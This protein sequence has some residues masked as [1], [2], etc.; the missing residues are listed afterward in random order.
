MANAVNQAEAL[1]VALQKATTN[2]GLSFIEMKKSLRESGTSV[3]NMVRVLAS[4]GPE[5][6]GSFNIAL[7]SLA[8]AN[9]NVI[10]ISKK[11]QEVKR[12][13]VQSIKFTAAQTAI[14]E[15]S[16]L[17]SE[18][19]RWVKE[20]NTE[21]ANIG[22]VT[23]KTGAQLETL[24]TNIIE[25]SRQLK[26]SA[27]E[28]AQAALIFYQQGL[29]DTQVEKRTQITIQ[30]AKAADQSVETMAQQLTAIWNTYG[31]IGEEQSRAASVGAKL[32]ASTAVDFADIAEAMQVSAAAAA[33][34]G[35]SYDSLGAIIATVGDTTQQSASVI[36]NAYKTIFSRFQQL[37]TEGTDGEVTLN[38]VSS[39]LQ[40]LGVD[41]LDASGKLKELDDVI[42]ATGLSWENYS[43]EQQLAIAELVGGTRQYGQFLALMNNFDKYLNLKDI[44]EKEDGSTLVQQFITAQDTAEVAAD[45]AREAWSKAIGQIVQGGDI[46]KFYEVIEKI[47]DAFGW[48]V[49]KVGDLD[50]VLLLVIASA[51]K[52]FSGQI[53]NEII[54]IGD[55]IGN[56][57]PS[58]QRKIV[59]YEADEMRNNLKKDAA[60]PKSKMDEY[61]VKISEAQIDQYQ[62]IS[63]AM[64]DVNKLATSGNAM[65]MAKAESLREQLKLRQ[66]EFNEAAAKAKELDK[67]AQRQKEALALQQELIDGQQTLT[68][69][70]QAQKIVLTE[71]LEEERQSLQFL[72]DA[73]LED[74]E[75]LKI[76][77]A[78]LELQ[79]QEAELKAASLRQKAEENLASTTGDN[80]ISN[81]ESARLA[82]LASQQNAD[83][84]VLEN[85]IAEERE[86][87]ALMKQQIEAKK[88]LTSEETETIRAAQEA[89]KATEEELKHLQDL[90]D[91]LSGSKKNLVEI[92]KNFLSVAQTL[93]KAKL[94][95][96]VVDV[97]GFKKSMNDILDLVDDLSEEQKEKLR[98]IFE[99]LGT[100]GEA[101][102]QS[103][104]E[105]FQQMKQGLE[106][107]VIDIDV[108]TE[109]LEELMKNLQQLQSSTDG[110]DST[111]SHISAAAEEFQGSAQKFVE[112]IITTMASAAIMV[113]S[114][115]NITGEF[116]TLFLELSNGTLTFEQF[117]DSLATIGTQLIMLIPSGLEFLGSIKGLKENLD[118]A[119]SSVFKLIDA[120]ILEEGAQNAS[121]AAKIASTVA[122]KAQNLI[123]AF[124]A[125]SFDAE[126]TAAAR[127]TL[128]TKG[129]TAALLKSP[130]FPVVV[131]IMAVVGALLALKAIFDAIV[132]AEKK[133]R[134][135]LAKIA[136]EAREAAQTQ[137]DLAESTNELANEYENARQVM[138]EA[139]EVF[140]NST[141]SIEEQKAAQERMAEAQATLISSAEGMID[142]LQDYIDSVNEGAA[143]EEEKLKTELEE[144]LAIATLTEN[145]EKLN[146][147]MSKVNEKELS[148]S[149]IKSQQSVAAS[150]DSLI[151]ET[152]AAS[153]TNDAHYISGGQDDNDEKKT[154][155]ALEKGEYSRILKRGNNLK[156]D[157]GDSAEDMAA[158]IEEALQLEKELQLSMTDQERQQSET[159]QALEKW[160]ESTSEAYARYGEAVSEVTASSLELLALNPSEWEKTMNEAGKS[161]ELTEED[162]QVLTIPEEGF[163]SFKEYDAYVEKMIEIGTQTGLTE[164]AIKS[165]LLTNTKT[166]PMAK[167][168]TYIDSQVE[169]L[170]NL[171]EEAKKAGKEVPALSITPGEYEQQLKEIYNNLPEDQK[172]FFVQLELDPNSDLQSQVQEQIEK[173][174][175]NADV[176]IVTNVSTEIAQEMSDFDMSSMNGSE[177]IAWLNDINQKINEYN[178]A[179][180]RLYGQGAQTLPELSSGFLSL[181]QAEQ[182]VISIA[183][184]A[185]EGN[186]KVVES[187]EERKNV[188]DALVQKHRELQE[189]LA[190]G[191]NTEVIDQIK[192]EIDTL[193]DDLKNRD[194][195][196]KIDIDEA[197]KKNF[198]AMETAIDTLV[199]K[200]HSVGEMNDLFSSK[201]IKKVG[202][203]FRLTYK[204]MEKV[205][206]QFP[207]LL[208]KAEIYADGTIG[209]NQQVVKNFLKGKEAE[210]IGDSEAAISKLENAKK[211]LQ[212]RRAALEAALEASL[213]ASLTE[214]QASQLLTQAL[215]EDKKKVQSA[216]YQAA[217]NGAAAVTKAFENQQENSGLAATAIA[218]NAYDAAE[219]E[220]KASKEASDVQIGNTNAVG[221]ANSDVFSQIPKIWKGAFSKAAGLAGKILNGLIGGLNFLIKAG[222]A[223]GM[224]IP[225]I[226]F[227]FDESGGDGG[228]TFKEA[229]KGTL[230]GIIDGAAETIGETVKSVK[231][232]IEQ[233]E[234]DV[235]TSTGESK[236][237]ALRG[238]AEQRISEIDPQLGKLNAFIAEIRYHENADLESYTPDDPRDPHGDEDDKKGKGKKDK[239]DKEKKD[240]ELQDLSQYDLDELERYENNLNALER[241]NRELERTSKAADD[242][243]GSGRIVQLRLYQK[244]LERV[245]KQQKALIDETKAYYKIDRYKIENSPFGKLLQ[246][247]DGEYGDLTN[248]EQIREWLLLQEQLANI[249]LENAKQIFNASAK[250]EAAEAV[251]EQAEK[252][253]EVRLA[254]IEEMRGWL[255]QFLETY[256]LLQERID[257]Q[258]ENIRKE[259]Q[260]KL[261]DITYRMEF[262][263]GINDY[264]LKQLEQA[265]DHLGIIGTRTTKSLQKIVGGFGEI[266]DNVDISIKGFNELL[267]LRNSLNTPEGTAEYIKRYGKDAWDDYMKN[268]GLPQELMAEIEGIVEALD[269]YEEQ[270]YEKNAQMFDQYRTLIDYWIREFDKINESLDQQLT[271]LELYDRV[272]R[273]TG[274]Q[275]TAKGRETMMQIAQARLDTAKVQRE[276]ATQ[277]KQIMQSEY[278]TSLERLNQYRLDTFGLGKY[279]EDNRSPTGGEEYEVDMLNKLTEQVE[280]NHEALME[281][282]N[283]E[284]GCLNSILDEAE[285]IFE[286]AKEQA[287]YKLGEDL[288]GLFYD[289]NDMTS[290]Y[291]KKEE[292]DTWY[293]DDYDKKYHLDRLSG[294]VTSDIED[295]SDPELLK[296]ATEFQE[297][298]NAL[299][300]EGV[301]L[302]EH[303]IEILEKEWELEKAKAAWD[304]SQQAKNTMRLT[305]DASGN[306]S[307]VYSADQGSE[308]ED[309]QQKIKD[310]EYEIKKMHENLSRES[311]QAWLQNRQEF[312]QYL[313]E[314]DWAMYE[315]DARYKAEVDATIQY[316]QERS[317]RFAQEINEHTAAI[318]KQFTDTTLSV[319]TNTNE[320]DD[321]EKLYTE[322]YNK[323]VESLKEAT[324]DYQNT[325]DQELKKV[326]GDFTDVEDHIR[327]K[328]SDIVDSNKQAE[329]AISNLRSTADAE[330]RAMNSAITTWVQ[331]WTS[332]MSALIAKIKEAE[333]A[334]RQLQ[335]QEAQKMDDISGYYDK[336]TDYTSLFGNL[337]NAY[338][339]N[340][341]DMSPEEY[342]NKNSWIV[343]QVYA[344]MMN[345]DR[346]GDNYKG[347]DPNFSRDDAY[348][349]LINGWQGFRPGDW[350]FG[351]EGTNIKIDIDKVM[352]N[353]EKHDIMPTASG[354]LIKTPQVRSLAEEGPELVL[355]AEDTENILRAVKYMRET[356][357]AQM[358][359]A[360]DKQYAAIQEKVSHAS[361]TR[362]NHD[363]EYKA[364]LDAA[365]AGQ[366]QK[367]QIEAH[368][369]GVTAASEIEEAFNQLITQAAQYRIRQDR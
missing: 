338:Y 260:A 166:S 90:E 279:G 231:A 25:G 98:E 290:I 237:E 357:Q 215:V 345:D 74:I 352:V 135:H 110:I 159:Y 249:D 324:R 268:G 216:E 56:A 38:M 258:T 24:Y 217:I 309:A 318:G 36:G 1:K 243:W 301:Q 140:T 350:N 54:K 328:V 163:T 50:T 308:A 347:E 89:L 229:T 337:Y 68:D 165:F 189:A 263:I 351:T 30:S 264:D 247:E 95:D 188:Y 232:E 322:N 230:R 23:G 361:S 14:R 310:L 364:Y 93:Q 257:E 270:L 19:I 55:A 193:E 256:D 167:M 180:I 313:S 152:K 175:R 190:N 219:Q 155:S 286:L 111:I 129:F 171:Q 39:K 60:S 355:N 130:L 250:D 67:E 73:N 287:K 281:A 102:F 115:G 186:A 341:G 206:E 168:E 133:H 149:V 103:I 151:A 233:T 212:G 271:R 236:L 327:D 201:D 356:V 221:Q 177:Q 143:A 200:I 293:L 226:T 311:Q 154:Y 105:A 203:S 80:F 354:G 366:E 342:L 343:D 64:I 119:A 97:D 53:S 109:A 147:V 182:E 153:K 208:A 234:I 296:K 187:L 131:A 335:N 170:K 8:T 254:E 197:T 29:D 218:E 223:L 291:D 100:E 108:S 77:K 16:Q 303:D 142:V 304:E 274:K 251:Y 121:T 63:T 17:T 20:L 225:E 22:V 199:D 289:P 273:T 196:I 86:R 207:E 87:L 334:L 239:K 224:G 323:Y 27:K 116:T 315:S 10:Q 360:W 252:A 253:R 145:Y 69:E 92:K 312:F 298:I 76:K 262:K 127:A 169:A 91:N 44:A 205:A 314:V 107:E 344:A 325:T 37:T 191:A 83:A 369:P 255:D 160:L 120:L 368:F 330:L 295:I 179:L 248:P 244:Q 99:S 202:D 333:E 150:G 65:E 339:M 18:S 269:G 192:S 211:E 292:L 210:L 112:S 21:I 321:A 261:D 43:K 259:L 348:Q 184:S 299:R 176:E 41:V 42:M 282:E 346:R 319:V 181:S 132:N 195:Q 173:L 104:L 125:G 183:Y 235:D 161:I 72:Q 157:I 194:L 367:V 113:E 5:F 317:E 174:Q 276:S 75:S 12:V 359:A 326:E 7:S 28:Y 35:V 283:E 349:H 46:Q 316:Y 88:N 32:A 2:K 71:K 329:K 267:E 9:R 228:T 305:R 70:Q 139:D 94:T 148:N 146:E 246:F 78:Q 31:M 81:E 82:E 214:E 320:M 134:E 122:S 178:E 198:E 272:M 33:Q 141:T 209:L 138:E 128:A 136:T 285:A 13:M 340:G 302:R 265:I 288:G 307:Y 242:A 124:L 58:G 47:G 275:N 240:K 336:D 363:E 241:Y 300:E 362:Y 158:A 172:K 332:Q 106:G 137:R 57:T 51:A 266:G 6:A 59:K 331:T 123:N 306:Y 156:I 96:E 126:A 185:I 34:M 85:I 222:N 45:R 280:A 101:S 278:D 48:I 117:G 220:A 4:A 61:N 144:A 204:Q 114:I 52:L 15:F 162:K 62:K 294:E 40:S 164:D 297:K 3:E 118:G 79:I 284:I 227:K 11:I 358:G 213:D 277:K 49:D 66:Q 353:G 365:L 26:V 245:G 238:E 84:A